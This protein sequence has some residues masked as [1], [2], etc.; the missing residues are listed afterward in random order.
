MTSNAMENAPATK[1]TPDMVEIPDTGTSVYQAL[2]QRRMAWAFKDDPVPEESVRRM[3]D[4]AVWAPNHRLTEPWRFFVLEKGSQKRQEAA[5]L[6]YD[7]AM[8]RNDNPVRGEASREMVLGA[9]ML[10]YVYTVPGRHE[11]ETRENYG[12]V[13]C[14]VQNIALAGVAEGLAVTWETGGI[15]RPPKLKEALGAEEDWIMTAMLSIG[16]P[17]ENLS[18]PRTPASQFVNWFK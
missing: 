2:F 4:T 6:A 7:H 15:T 11:E 12:A 16:V 1:Q 9:P 17:D 13:C 8:E 14:A 18:P 3:L 5:Q 10:V